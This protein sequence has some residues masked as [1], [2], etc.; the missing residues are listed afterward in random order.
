MEVLEDKDE[1]DGN[2]KRVK[3]RSWMRRRGE[4]GCFDNIFAELSAED[5]S[6][7]REM[8]RMSKEDY[9]YILIKIEKYITP[10][11]IIGG[12]E[13]INAKARLALTLRFL[14]TGETYR[15]LCFQFRISRAAISYI[16][17]QVCKAIRIHLAEYMTVPNTTKEW[18]VISAKCGERWNYPNCIGAVDGKHIVMQPPANAGSKFYNY[19]HTHSIVL[20]AVAGPDYECIYADIGTN[21]RVS[22]GGVWNKCTLSKKIETGELSLPAPSCLPL[23]EKVVPFVF[24]GDGAFALKPNMMKPYPQTGLTEDKRIYNYR[25]SRARH[26][27]ENL[28]GILANRWR[29]F[30]SV[31]LLPPETIEHLVLATLTLHNFLRKSSSRNVYCPPGLADMVDKTGNLTSGRWHANPPTE[32]MFKLQAPSSGHNASSNAKAIR[33]TL[34]DYFCYEGAISWQWSK[35]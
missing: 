1:L 34:K 15:S 20:M 24:V 29:V 30:R 21:G 13:I 10:N 6:S 3:T 35:L 11:Q 19:T 4:K 8:I 22:D 25:H 26:I 27:S 31:I 33:E 5:T 7:F 12:H 32:S 16:I 17:V 2:A 14:A 28:F 18:S 9:N 23:S